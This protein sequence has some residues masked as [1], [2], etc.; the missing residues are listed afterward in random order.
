VPTPRVDRALVVAVRRALAE[1][2]DPSRSAGMA[3][4]MKSTL[5]FRGVTKPARV[6]ALRPVFAAHPVT[7][8]GCWAATVRALYDEAVYREERYAAL[9]LLD[10]RAARPWRDAALVPLLE[11]LVVEG[12][13]W[14]LVDELA[15]RHVAPLHRAH[16]LELAPVIRR[17]A[18][19]DDL[20]LRRAAVLSQLGS[21]G[22]TDRV[23][24]VD[25][26]EANAGSREFF[27][28]K[29]IGW[30]LRDLAHHDPDWVRSYLADAG[31]RLAPLSRREAGKHLGVG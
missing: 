2:A 18:G 6:A 29:A 13:W 1:S 10:V 3:A 16:P 23:L 7:D 26:I 28:R 30:A 19:S 25:V 20:W 24:L 14:D 9:A 8:R 4:Y 15:A 17:W 22:A 5:P 11:H 31:D 12:A 21:K 27:L